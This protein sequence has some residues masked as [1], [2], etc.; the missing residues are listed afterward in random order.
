VVFSYFIYICMKA[1]VLSRLFVHPDQ[2][3]DG[4]WK[5]GY[6]HYF[7]NSNTNMTATQTCDVR[8]T[9]NVGGLEIFCGKRSLKNMKFL[10]K[11]RVIEGKLK[12]TWRCGRKC[13]Q[14]L[15]DHKKK[16]RYRNL[17]EQVLDCAV[18]TTCYK[19][20]YIVNKTMFYRMWNKNLIVYRICN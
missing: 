1:V 5:N 14:L 12:W 13:K 20:E 8:M 19:I 18:W 2:L 11:E 15:D 17:K 9:I 3:L 10:W 7:I 4:L 16:K 6:Q